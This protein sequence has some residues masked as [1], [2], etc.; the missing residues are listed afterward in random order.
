MAVYAVPVPAPSIQITGKI[1]KKINRLARCPRIVEKTISSPEKP[2]TKFAHIE[3]AVNRLARQLV[4]NAHLANGYEVVVDKSE[5]AGI[6][7]TNHIVINPGHC[8]SMRTIDVPG[9]IGRQ[10]KVRDVV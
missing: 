7:C 10:C 3:Q 6:N 1:V 8:R 5:N 9:R 2:V 4:S